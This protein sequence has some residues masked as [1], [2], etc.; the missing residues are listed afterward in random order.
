MFDELDRELE[1]R[2]HRFARYA[3]DLVPRAKGPKGPE[4]RNCFTDEGRPLGT[5][6][7]EQVPNR[8]WR[9]WATTM[10]VSADG[11]TQVRRLRDRHGGTLR[12]K[13]PHRDLQSLTSWIHDNNRT[14]APLGVANSLENSVAERMKRIQDLYA[15]I[16]RAQGIVGADGF[17]H[18]STAS[19]PAAVSARMAFAGLDARNNRSFSP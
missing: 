10:V 5:G 4:V 2:N 14:V 17:I 19:F 9:L 12:G 16:F 6:L 15:R 8:L 3:D 13:H 1:R 11:A 7:Q 18:I